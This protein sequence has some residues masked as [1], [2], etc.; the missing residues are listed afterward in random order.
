MAP[1]NN[2]HNQYLLTTAQMGAVGLFALLALY[3]IYWR[4]AR[5]LE[6]PYA[7]LAMAVLLGFLLGNLFNSFMMD[8]AERIFF[9]W[10]T[11]LFFSVQSTGLEHG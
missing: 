5:R 2:P 11:G 4:A 3:G 10:T 7:Q 1:S 8:F 9:A 6:P